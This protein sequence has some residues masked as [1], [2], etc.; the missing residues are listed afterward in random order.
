[1]ARKF[2]VLCYSG[3]GVS[4]ASLAHTLKS[5]RALLS[6]YYTVN[7]IT[8]ETLLADPWHTQC[9]L[10]VFPGGRDIP[11]HAALQGKGNE[12]IQKFVREG[13]SFL[14]ICAGGYYGQ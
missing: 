9:A 5:L 12:L 7:P 8:T 1:M 6:P 13:G 3:A 4:P 11:F 14:G 10:L 2:S